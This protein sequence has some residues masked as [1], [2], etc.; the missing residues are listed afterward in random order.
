MHL[1]ILYSYLIIST[2]KLFSKFYLCVAKIII[3]L[4]KIKNFHEKLKKNI[5]M[6]AYIF[7]TIKFT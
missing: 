3:T 2:Q 7:Y 5:F 4:Y 1:N 6:H